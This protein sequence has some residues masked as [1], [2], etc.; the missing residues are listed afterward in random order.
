MSVIKFSAE[1]IRRPEDSSVTAVRDEDATE[2]NGEVCGNYYEDESGRPIRPA[3][4]SHLVV[5][6]F[7]P[8]TTPRYFAVPR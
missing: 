3:L 5:T 1:D 6:G 8:P 7:E 2:C 4:H